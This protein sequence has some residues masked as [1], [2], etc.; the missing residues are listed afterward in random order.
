MTTRVD[1]HLHLWDLHVRDQPWLAPDAPIR[2][3]F[4]VADLRA[5]ADGTGIAAGVLVQVLNRTD[6]TEDL[7]RVAAG[8]PF[9]AGV[10]GWADLTSAALADELARLTDLGP[11]VG[12][13]HQLQAERDPAGWLVRD[14]L[15]AGLAALA[16]AGLPFDLMLRP[17]QLE[18]ARECVRGHPDVQFV[19]DHCGKPA[20][21]SG[22]L[23]EWRA[24][25]A[26]L[27]AA[28][29]VVCKLSGLV[30]EAEHASW[31]V[32]QLRPVVDAVLERF[33]PQRTMFG[34]DWPVCLHAATYRQVVD[35]VDLLIA[36]LTAAER[37][38]VWS[39]TACRVYSVEATVTG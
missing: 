28:P 4:G 1:A 25:L 8:E 15:S 24:G 32:D 21:S 30:N 9:I 5:A 37:A 19:V 11:L 31:T 26:E 22:D 13:R 18:A 34:S 7:L 3:D 23:R 33:G 29:N 38:E 14:D 10:V 6:E 36:P 16:A 39:G 12:V 35:A 2:R 27:A 17:P 20:I